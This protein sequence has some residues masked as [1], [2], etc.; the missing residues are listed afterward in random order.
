MEAEECP[1]L[2]VM[3]ALDNGGGGISVKQSGPALPPFQQPSATTSFRAKEQQAPPGTGHRTS[4][5][6]APRGRGRAGV[7]SAG[8]LPAS[9]PLSHQRPDVH[10]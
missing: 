10:P 6:Q 5:V 3:Q 4:G 8:K 2:L 9:L 1:D 7:E